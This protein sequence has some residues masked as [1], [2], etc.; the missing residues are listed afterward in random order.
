MSFSIKKNIMPCASLLLAIKTAK[1]VWLGGVTMKVAREQGIFY[2]CSET[3]TKK[4]KTF[5]FYVN[6]ETVTDHIAHEK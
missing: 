5:Y 1:R 3:I 2:F 6:S 4:M